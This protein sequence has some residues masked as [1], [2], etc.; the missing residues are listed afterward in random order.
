M[1]TEN[2]ELEG[3]KL[4]ILQEN[5]EEETETTPDFEEIELSTL[6]KLPPK[7]KIEPRTPEHF[8]LIEKIFSY[9]KTFP[10]ECAHIQTDKFDKLSF[11][12]L[13]GMAEMCRKSAADRKDGQIHKLGFKAVLSFSEIYLAPKLKMNLRGLTNTAMKDDDL[14]KTLDEIA[15]AQDWT[16]RNIPPEQRLI[17]GLGVLALRINNANKLTEKAQNLH[18]S[19]ET[20][21]ET[22][23][24]DEL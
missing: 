15:L 22:E 13:Q 3:E 11:A 23:K 17:F 16:T 21:T 9:K 6:N 10:N 18:I 14:M 24:F 12:E 1:A 4:D 2:I 19:Q 5:N 20:T 7:P 8:A